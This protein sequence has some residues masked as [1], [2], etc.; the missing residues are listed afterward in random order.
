MLMLKLMERKLKGKETKVTSS[1]SLKYVNLQCPAVFAEKPKRPPQVRRRPKTNNHKI[2]VP[3]YTG[4][5]PELFSIRQLTAQ[6]IEERS[7]PYS[8]LNERTDVTEDDSVQLRRKVVFTRRENVTEVSSSDPYY[9][10]SLG[11]Y[12]V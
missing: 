4:E 12:Y 5:T 7:R 3:A 2:R 10:L 9:D 6:P 1:P 8:P 11:S